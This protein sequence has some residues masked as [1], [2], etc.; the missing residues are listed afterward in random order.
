[1]HLERDASQSTTTTAFHTTDHRHDTQGP[2]TRIAS[3]CSEEELA[4]LEKAYAKLD[5]GRGQFRLHATPDF[6]KDKKTGK[7][8][9]FYNSA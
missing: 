9:Y 5:G 1:M 7:T 6:S 2:I 8:Y 3:G 4:A